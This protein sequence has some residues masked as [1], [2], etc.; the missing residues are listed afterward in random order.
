MIL[1]DGVHK[2]PKYH[3]NPLQFRPERFSPENLIGLD[4]YSYLPF[5]HGPRNCIGLLKDNCS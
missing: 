1:I 5:S 2:N 4:P 3:P